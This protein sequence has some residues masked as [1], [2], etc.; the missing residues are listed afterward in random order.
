[1]KQFMLN[2]EDDVHKDIKTYA[3]NSGITM[4]E[5]INELI[6]TH[7]SESEHAALKSKKHISRDYIQTDSKE[8]V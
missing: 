1:M 7:L 6:R 3:A 8:S 4:Q 5:Y 2:L